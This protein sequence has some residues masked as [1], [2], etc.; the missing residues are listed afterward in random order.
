M[1]VLLFIPCLTDA[2]ATRA[3]IAVVRV[4]E[5]LGCEV[6]FPAG[7]TCCGQ[8]LSNNGLTAEAR[9]L[10]RRMVE[11]F[12]GDVWVVTPSGSCAAM[13]HERFARLLADEADLAGPA[14]GLARR[15]REFCEFLVNELRAELRGCRLPRPLRATYHAPC[16]LRAIGVRDEPLRLLRQIEGLELAPLQRAA[17]CCGFGGLFATKMP[18]ISVA[19]GRD[20]LA[21]AQATGAAVVVSNEAGCTLHLDGLA[22]RAGTPLRFV[23]VAELIAEG[24]G[25]LAPAEEPA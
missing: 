12:A 10:A 2:F 19:M 6:E 1:R 22:R 24:L 4:L 17:D 18:E 15:T 5:H 25:L 8:P 14:A 7:Q 20:K 9:E 23:T 3:G 11:L 16:H 13:I 21:D